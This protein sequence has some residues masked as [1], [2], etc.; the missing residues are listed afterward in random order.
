V[1][2]K[3]DSVK[4]LLAFF[5]FS[6]SM[7]ADAAPPSKC[8]GIRCIV[9]LGCEVIPAKGQCCQKCKNGMYKS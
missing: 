5:L 3:M 2:E 9:P 6:Y 4:F 7:I 1:Q 8:A